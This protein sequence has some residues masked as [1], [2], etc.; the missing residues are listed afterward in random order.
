[1]LHEM[2]IVFTEERNFLFSPLFGFI[3]MIILIILVILLV[4][5][6][7]RN[8]SKNHALQTSMKKYEKLNKEN[9]KL[10]TM[11]HDVSDA[12]NQLKLKYDELLAS[13]D[14][15]KKLAYFDH[16]TQLPNRLSLIELLDSVML[17]LRSDEIIAVLHLNIDK[18]KRINHE[19]GYSYGDELLIDVTHRM[20]QVIDENDYLA[21]ISGDEFVIVTQNIQDTTEYE[22]KLKR[23]LN[24]FSYPFVLSNQERFIS[25]SMGISFAP[26]DGKTTTSLLKN[27]GA[28]MVVAKKTGKN[29]YIYFED[30]MN[31]KITDRIQLQSELREGLE[32]N[33]FVLYYEP[34]LHLK[35]EK[36]VGFET[37]ICWEH[38]TKGLLYPKDFIDIAEETGIIAPIGIWAFKEACQQMKKWEEEGY[39]D[40]K[41]AFNITMLEF[42]DPEFISI[43]W[44]IVSK[45]GIN[46]N[47]LAI[48][49]TEATALDDVQYT[50]ATINKLNELG[51][52]FNL[53]NYGTNYSSIRYLKQLP[54]LN[55]KIDRIFLDSIFESTHE[56]NIVQGVISLLKAFEFNVIAEGVEE[57]EQHLFLAEAN[58]DMAQGVLYSKPLPAD[59]AFEFLRKGDFRNKSEE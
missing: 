54:V 41:L 36:T 56:K 35:S 7:S 42:M 18:F 17:T 13:N 19:L 27:A 5:L 32:K 14:K 55:I 21:R 58:C 49:I 2:E 15:I 23:I 1:M 44:D 22:D 26:K 10:E 11:F 51:V 38:P 59:Q 31:Q 47:N 12:Q 37:K 34:I 57:E 50:N 3:L 8:R 30:S 43:I 9:N 20:K 45:T 4:V 29:V 40:I 52:V 53:D 16:L 24:V 46:P 6:F 33:E 48:E 25:V 39:P 28:A